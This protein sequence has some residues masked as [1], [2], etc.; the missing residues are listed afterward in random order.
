MDTSIYGRSPLEASSFIVSSAFPD[1]A[2]HASGFLARLSGT[3][4]EFLSMWNHMMVGP[5]PFSLSAD[6]KLQVSLAPVIADWM[7]RDDGTLNFKFLGSIDVTYVMSSKK[8][9]WESTIKSYDLKDA[10][11]ATTHVDGSVVP[12]PLAQAVRD[13]KFTS[14]TV[15][16]A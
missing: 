14:M 11:G 3:T 13:I 7:W 2:L 8:N 1:K 6:K 16:F 5:T 4:A 15:T 10:S 9:S 12:S